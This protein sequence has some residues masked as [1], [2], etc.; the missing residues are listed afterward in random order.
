TFY[1]EFRFK[2]PPKVEVQVCTALPCYLKGSEEEYRKIEKEAV[3]IPNVEVGRCPCLGRCDTAGAMTVNG[4]IFDAST[5][6][7]LSEIA[8]RYVQWAQTA[9]GEEPPAHGHQIEPP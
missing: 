3:G 9:I 7:T 4:H 2:R 1:P 5:P 8:A 6:G